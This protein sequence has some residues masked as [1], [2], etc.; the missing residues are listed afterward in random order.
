[1]LEEFLAS[2]ATSQIAV[3][4]LHWGVR[5]QLRWLPCWRMRPRQLSPVSA[6]VAFSEGSRHCP[7]MPIWCCGHHPHAPL[8]GQRTRSRCRLS[9]SSQCSSRRIPGRHRSSTHLRTNLAPR[10]L[11]RIGVKMPVENKQTNKGTD[12]MSATNSIN[13]Y[14]AKDSV[15]RKYVHYYAFIYFIYLERPARKMTI[16]QH[17]FSK[18]QRRKN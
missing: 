13:R 6:P 18:V 8:S 14:N 4:A 11:N 2:I 15:S 1:M 9:R 17:Q 12:R 5:L 3:C 7:S 10:P 16:E